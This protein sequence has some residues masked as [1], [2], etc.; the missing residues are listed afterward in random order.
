M[1]E[2]LLL[3][4]GA[5]RRLVHFHHF[6]GVHDLQVGRNRAELVQLGLERGLVADE[7]KPF[8]AER[9]LPRGLN[10]SID[11]FDGGE[12]AAHRVNSN[13]HQASVVTVRT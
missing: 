7:Q 12:I 2:S 1:D 5:D 11:D 3:A 4:Q 10:G 13:A 6:R 9:G 8:D